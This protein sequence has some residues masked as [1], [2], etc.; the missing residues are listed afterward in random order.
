M[1]DSLLVSQRGEANMAVRH[2]SRGQRGIM[3]EGIMATWQRVKGHRGI[4]YRGNMA[5]GIVLRWQRAEGHRGNRY[6]GKGHKGIV[7]RGIV[8]KGKGASCQ[9]WQ[10]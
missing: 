10:Y 6:R 5:R 4:C 2:A 1:L 3:A 8:A 9:T 7:A